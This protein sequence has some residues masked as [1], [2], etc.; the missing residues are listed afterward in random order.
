MSDDNVI[1]D[2][3]QMIARYNQTNPKRDADWNAIKVQMQEGHD[4]FARLNGWAVTKRSSYESLIPREQR[5]GSSWG[6]YYPRQWSEYVGGVSDHDF[7]CR[8]ARGPRPFPVTAV[9]CQP[10][11]DH[12]DEATAAAERLGLAVH[13]P[14]NPHACFWYP[15]FTR[16]Y[17]FTRPGVEVKWL[18]EQSILEP[19][20]RVVEPEER[21]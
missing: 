21:T 12:T 19:S 1:S 2:I 13:I 11:N 6:R 15:G 5:R 20:Y 17:V 9:I 4:A 8:D 7:A 16:I 14:P 3:A 18:P 10:Y